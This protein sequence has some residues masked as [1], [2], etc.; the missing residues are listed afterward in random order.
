MVARYERSHDATV[1]VL[2]TGCE[3]SLWIAEQFASDLHNAFPRLNIVCISANKLLAQC[4]QVRKL[5]PFFYRCVNTCY[6]VLVSRP[7]FTTHSRGSTS[8]VSLRISFSRSA[9][10]YGF[11]KGM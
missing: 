3:V 5:D 11:S 1:D 10:R 7:T 2:L 6:Y 9:D 8:S 4:G